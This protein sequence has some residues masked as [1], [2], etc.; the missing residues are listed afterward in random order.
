MKKTFA[1]SLSAV[2]L[3]TSGP[4]A[5][6]AAAAV[7][8]RAASAP[9]SASAV[10]GAPVGVL[11]PSVSMGAERIS[12]A[13]SGALPTL[14]TLPS[15]TLPLAS[16]AA[17]SASAPGEP[18][19]AS[20]PSS[21]PGVKTP[22]S[23]T[24]AK[25]PAARAS[26][27]KVAEALSSNAPAPESAAKGGI[28]TRFFDAT[29]KAPEGAVIAADAAPRARAIAGLQP[30]SA[31]DLRR[32]A[33]AAAPAAAVTT[34]AADP[35]LPARLIEWIASLPGVETVI[36]WFTLL[37]GWAQTGL[38]VGA[39]F[40]AA[41]VAPKIVRPVAKWFFRQVEWNQLR[42]DWLT[43]VVAYASWFGAVTYAVGMVGG[44]Q[45]LAVNG[46][47]FALTTTLAVSDVAANVADGFFLYQNRTLKIGERFEALGAK[48]VLEAA[49][50]R[51]IVVDQTGEDGA[52]WDRILIPNEKME[53]EG[54]GGVASENDPESRR[55][56]GAAGLSLASAA[57][58]W[59]S[60]GEVGQS[61]AILAGGAWLGR[62]LSA[63]YRATDAKAESFRGTDLES[64]RKFRKRATVLWW[65]RNGV[66]MAG[67]SLVLH[68]F[69]VPVSGMVGA[70]SIFSAAAGFYMKSVSGNLV[71]GLM[72]AAYLPFNVGDTVEIG[73]YKGVVAG[74]S[75]SELRLWTGEWKDGSRAYVDVPLTF[76]MKEVIKIRPL[77]S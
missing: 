40:G 39:G 6:P 44:W 9:T 1:A 32:F 74:M 14:S 77:R 3:W 45:A 59:T 34:A 13:F 72:I 26:L 38:W 36:Q 52:E 69:G 71:G 11:A 47:V 29:A 49:N 46:S 67:M 4:G 75:Q 16:V 53:K 41:S 5:A 20:F 19:A 33:A 24:S 18:R 68:L 28:S 62:R 27:V 73:K 7:L 64:F 12:P 21:S 22:R 56:Q 2:L 17:V 57:A 58:F 60:L 35:T 50:P 76:V 63:W 30:A 23:V 65:F 31:G 70:L 37:P 66:Y 8:T 51:F 10:S 42:E 54:I 25:A 55:F 43:S 48:G 61:I 15:G